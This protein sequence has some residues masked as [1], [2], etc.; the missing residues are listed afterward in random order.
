MTVYVDTLI[1]HDLSKK[2]IRIQRV[3]REGA[4]HMFTD[5]PLED[6]HA[7]AE[8]IGMNR[9]WFQDEGDLPHYDLNPRRREAAVRAGAVECDKRKTVEVMRTNRAKRTA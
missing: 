5:G 6:L 4:C 2:P 1:K 3:F 7:M 9:S 8:R